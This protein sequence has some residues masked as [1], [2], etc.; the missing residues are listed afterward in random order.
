MRMEA[1]LH[2]T[3]IVKN[4]QSLFL[5]EGE[6]SELA[7]RV[8]SGEVQSSSNEGLLSGPGR[9]QTKKLVGLTKVTALQVL[10]PTGDR[11]SPNKEGTGLNLTM[12]EKTPVIIKD[13]GEIKEEAI[14]KIVRP[15]GTLEKIIAYGSPI[16]SGIAILAHWAGGEYKKGGS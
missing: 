5:G 4:A 12:G 3:E 14:D 9:G 1:V 15:T 6:Y 13:E 8:M 7:E 2:P 11:K 16:A 10:L